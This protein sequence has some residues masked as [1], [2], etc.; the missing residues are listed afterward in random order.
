MYVGRVVYRVENGLWLYA[1]IF[2]GTKIGTLPRLS[3]KL[4]YTAIF[5]IAVANVSLYYSS[6]TVVR[7]VNNGS[8]VEI[9]NKK[10]TVDY[11]GFFEYVDGLGD[12]ALVLLPLN[13]YM[14]LSFY[15]EPVYLSAKQGSWKKYIPMGFWTVKFPDIENHIQSVGVTNPF[16]DVVKKN[17]YVVDYPHLG[18]FLKNHY[19]YDAKCEKVK[20]FNGMVL[21]KYSLVEDSEK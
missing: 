13:Q 19:N 1:T 8:A 6:G 14:N 4:F 3:M 21:L 17:V 18:P 11:Q 7:N 10:D 15:K 20:D 16:E 12:S 5:V 9:V 2:M